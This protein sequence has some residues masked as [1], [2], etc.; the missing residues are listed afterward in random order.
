MREDSY[1]QVKLT[2]EGHACQHDILYKVFGEKGDYVAAACL[3]GANFADTQSGGFTG[4]SH[5]EELKQQIGES[6]REYYLLNPDSFGG[7]KGTDVQVR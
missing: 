5:T 2:I 6:I 3:M 7:K 4:Y 1:F